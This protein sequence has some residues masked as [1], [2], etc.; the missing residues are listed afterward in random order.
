VKASGTKLATYQTDTIHDHIISRKGMKEMNGPVDQLHEGAIV[1]LRGTQRL[2]LLLK[3]S[4][5]GLDR[6]AGYELVEDLMLDQVGSCSALEF[7][8][9]GF[10]E[11]SQLLRGMGRHGDEGTC[12]IVEDRWGDC[13]CC[14][15]NTADG[16]TA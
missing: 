6:L 16:D 10:E 7:I 8:Q 2:G 1:A 3:D 13:E 14:T 9:S 5:D 12:L 15:S 11:Q 4:Q